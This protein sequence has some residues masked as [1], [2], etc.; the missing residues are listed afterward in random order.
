MPEL[1]RVELTPSIGISLQEI[2]DYI[3]QDSPRH[4]TRMID[5]ILRAIDGLE[6]FPK[7]QMAPGQENEANPIRSL[8]VDN[9][10]IYYDVDDVM[11][12]VRILRVIHGAQ[13]QASWFK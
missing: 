2:F 4:A 5:R 3:A 10:V 9:Y 7:R 12:V 11:K 6:I 1:Y 8:P 13:R